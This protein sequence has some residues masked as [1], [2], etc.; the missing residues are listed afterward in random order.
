MFVLLSVALLISLALTFLIALRELRDLRTP[1]RRYA[2]YSL[3]AILSLTAAVCA[4]LAVWPREIGLLCSPFFWC[5]FHFGPELLLI[6]IADVRGSHYDCR[7][8]LLRARRNVKRR[9]WWLRPWKTGYVP[10][11]Q[12]RDQQV[13]IDYR[14]PRN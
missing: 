11:R 8:H 5:A 4:G 6:V 14:E 10:G 9:R 12:G 2:R 13:G 3:R 1:W 7:P